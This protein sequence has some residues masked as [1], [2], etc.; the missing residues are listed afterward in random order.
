MKCE[1]CELLLARGEVNV[2]AEAHAMACPKCRALAELG[3]NA[4]AMR[5]LA[6]EVIPPAPMPERRAP[7]QWWKW[8][9]TAAAIIFTLGAGWW[10][11]RPAKPPHMVNIDVKV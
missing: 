11:S 5:A 6:D 10:F 3:A 7:N 9:S 1:E 4:A 2:E 8:S